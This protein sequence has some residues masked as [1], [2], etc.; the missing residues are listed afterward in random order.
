[1]FSFP[2]FTDEFCDM[3][4]SEI[5]HFSTAAPSL[6]IDIHRP[7]TMNRYGVIVNDMGLEGSI[8]ALQRDVLQ[9]V[10]RTL[11]PVHG[12]RVEHHHSFIVRYRPDEDLGLDMH[13][14]DSDVTFN[15]CLGKEFE[16]SGLQFCGMIGSETHRQATYSYAHRKG[17][18]VVH[19]GT[20]RHGADEITKGER[21][22]LIVWCRNRD[23]RESEF[24]DR[25]Q[26]PEGYE[27]ESGPPDPVCLSFTHD[28]DFGRYK[29]Y[30]EGTGPS[31]ARFR[32]WCPPPGR[33]ADD[34]PP[35]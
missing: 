13:T 30:P 9:T 16:A 5:D 22:N 33:E 28:R 24:Y 12:C 14:D 21:N 11:F 4:M 3:F 34:E 15:V 19:L 20:L 2:L 1:V 31:S 8:S 18:C 6:G 27:K 35:S 23:F 29:A 10:A 7:N 25:H 26:R 32:P 17:T